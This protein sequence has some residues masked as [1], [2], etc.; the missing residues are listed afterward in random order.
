MNSFTSGAV[1]TLNRLLD[2]ID[3]LNEESLDKVTLKTLLLSYKKMYLE[4]DNIRQ[5]SPIIDETW[6]KIEKANREGTISDDV[7]KDLE[8]IYKA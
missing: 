7:F 1:N 8:S 2:Y 3:T 4:L 5:G 6:K